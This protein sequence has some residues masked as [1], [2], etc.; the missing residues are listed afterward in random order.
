MKKKNKKVK[1]PK[2]IIGE[3]VKEINVDKLQNIA[4]LSFA[5]A[6]FAVILIV[7]LVCLGIMF[8]NWFV[9]LLCGIMLVYFITHSVMSVIRAST[10]PKYLLC[11]NCIVVNSIWH[12][13][14]WLIPIPLFGNCQV[15]R[16]VSDGCGAAQR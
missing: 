8:N 1:E 10:H 9:W 2:F 6:I 11:E 5:V 16:R 14:E 13:G 4:E 12:Y 15:V 3:K 7:G